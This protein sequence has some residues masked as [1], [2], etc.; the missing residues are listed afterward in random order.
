MLPGGK[1]SN[2]EIDYLPKFIKK[3]VLHLRLPRGLPYNKFRFQHL[4][5]KLGNGPFAF[6]YLYQQFN[7]RLTNFEGRLLN[8]RKS[9]REQ[10]TNLCVGKAKKARFILLLPAF[11]NPVTNCCEPVT[12]GEKSVGFYFLFL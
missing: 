3:Q 2:S 12:G 1:E 11:E 4:V 8:D 7:G 5:L 10:V 9:G 6:D